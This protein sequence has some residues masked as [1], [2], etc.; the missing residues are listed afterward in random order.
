[1]RMKGKTG[2]DIRYSTFDIL[3]FSVLLL[4]L[5]LGGCQTG[6]QPTPR[7]MAEPARDAGHSAR[8]SFFLNLS[9]SEGPGV[10]L[11]ISGLEVLTDGAWLPVTTGPLELDSEK[12]GSAQL[13]LG[14]RAVEPGLYQRLRFTV[15]KGLVRRNTG[16]YQ[17]VSQ[18]PYRVELNLPSPLHLEQ[19]DSRSLFLTWDVRETLER[20]GLHPV[21]TIA[22]Q[23]RQLLADLIYAA[24]PDI[25]T[26]FVIRSDRNWVADSFG[27]RGRPT[28]LAMDPDPGRQRLFVLASREPAI[29]V[30]D[31]SSQRVVDSFH[32]P[33]TDAP[34]F[35]TISPDGRS[36]YILEERA[37]YLSRIDLSTGRS[38]ARVRL[39]YRPQ[40][41][42]FLTER[43]L[44]AVSLG[45]TQRVSLLNPLS[46]AEVSS[47]LTGDSPQGLI[48]SDNQF[49]IAEYGDHTVSIF[50][51]SQSRLEVGFGPRRLLKTDK[52]IYVSN[53]DGD[54]LSVL[55]PGQLVVV[56]EIQGLARPL[57][58]AFDPARHQLYV[59][60]E[61][62]AGLAVIDSTSNLLSGRIT[63]GAKP[64]G[65]AVLPQ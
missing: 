36:A 38:A 35:M 29:K 33:L 27:I 62:A 46:L 22:P 54:S 21:M 49:Y 34:T 31:L 51:R 60:E 11:E 2:I 16:Q 45:L 52:F 5:L 50:N 56:R 4:A 41:A 9:E 42:A 58:M 14:S 10:R 64:V 37:S 12:I 23:L 13:F 17:A 3:R 1:M 39:E 65:L 32:L 25:D 15:D 30:V 6:A 20:E 18:D 47:I 53:Y 57:E 26:I 43:N 8:L 59:G 63:L 28:Y 7:L 61:Q 19:D 48:V 24:C 40:Y 55:L 44:L